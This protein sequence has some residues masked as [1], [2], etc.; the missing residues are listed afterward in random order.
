MKSGDYPDWSRW[1]RETLG[2]PAQWLKGTLAKIAIGDDNPAVVE[3]TKAKMDQLRKGLE[4]PHPTPIEAL[5]AERAVFCWFVVNAYEPLY[6]QSKDLTIR[7]SD[8]E[9]RRIESAHRRFLSAVATLARVRKL[10]LPALQVNI[11]ANQ[12]NVARTG[13]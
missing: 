10:A 11:G 7:R 8:F 5:L 6:I 3:V 1:F 12:L 13:R 2:N 9:V 4:G